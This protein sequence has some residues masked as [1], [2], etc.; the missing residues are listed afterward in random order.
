MRSVTRAQN[1]L[2]YYCG[3]DGTQKTSPRCRAGRAGHQSQS[4]RHCDE[5]QSHSVLSSSSRSC[6]RCTRLAAAA[7]LLS[8]ARAARSLRGLPA[9]G[10]TQCAKPPVAEAQRHCTTERARRQPLRAD[11]IP[12]CR[13]PRRAATHRRS[14][15]R[16]GLPVEYSA[17]GAGNA[18]H[19][20]TRSCAPLDE[21]PPRPQA[22]VMA[23]LRAAARRASAGGRCRARRGAGTAPQRSAGCRCRAAR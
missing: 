15:Q 17:G 14:R 7:A 21:A 23:P 8:S 16:V 10:C 6:R 9:A 11:A 12:R 2:H 5:L 1:A 19:V 4:R 22:R 18:S 13:D 3:I 20:L